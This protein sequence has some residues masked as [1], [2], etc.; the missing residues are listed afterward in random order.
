MAIS[1]WQIFVL[2]VGIMSFAAGTFLLTYSADLPDAGAKR[3]IRKK[4]WGLIGI[5]VAGILIAGI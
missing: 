2:A 5:F 3:R 1:T 4:G